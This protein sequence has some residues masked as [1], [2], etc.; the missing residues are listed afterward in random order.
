MCTVFLEDLSE[1]TTNSIPLQESQRSRVVWSD[2]VGLRIE[3]HPV[4]FNYIVHRHCVAT[5]LEDSAE[6]HHVT[7]LLSASLSRRTVLGSE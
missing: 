4:W 2:I 6:R 1:A 7:R 5:F 3:S